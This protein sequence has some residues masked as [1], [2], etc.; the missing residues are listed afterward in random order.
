M[1][2]WRG[3]ACWWGRPRQVRG[4]EWE[5]GLSW[6]ASFGVKLG[7][8]GC[9]IYRRVLFWSVV[10]VVVFGGVAAAGKTSCLRFLAAVTGHALREITLSSSADSTDI[11]GCFEQVDHSRDTDIVVVD[12]DTVATAVCQ[13]VLVAAAQGVAGEVPTALQI[14]ITHIETVVSAVTALKQHVD[15]HRGNVEEGP[16][17]QVTAVFP[18]LCHCQCAV[19]SATMQF[20]LRVL[21]P[22]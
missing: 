22:C 9:L 2:S 17:S 7:K 18:C 8:R 6:K 15:S 19:I 14:A 4:R 16:W 20:H 10:V 11:L 1:S 3:R 13:H 12:V 5:L 21:W